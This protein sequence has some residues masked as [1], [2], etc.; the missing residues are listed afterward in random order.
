MQPKLYVRYSTPRG[1]CSSGTTFKRGQGQQPRRVSPDKDTKAHADHNTQTRQRACKSAGHSG[2]AHT[3]TDV[4]FEN[5]SQKQAK[6][7]MCLKHSR[8]HT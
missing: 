5:G 7:E 4:L 2:T 6:S 8:G 1:R 3:K